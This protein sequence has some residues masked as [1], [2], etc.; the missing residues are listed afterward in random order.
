M[1]KILF[2]F[3]HFLNATMVG[4]NNLL[5]EIRKTVKVNII[6]SESQKGDANI[7]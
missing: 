6:S 5:M 2:K 7:V 3:V 1:N 4:D